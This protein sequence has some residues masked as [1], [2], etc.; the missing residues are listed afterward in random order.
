MAGLVVLPK[1]GWGRP[2][3]TAVPAAMCRRIRRKKGGVTHVLEKSVVGVAGVG[4][5]GVG[6]GGA[7]E[8]LHGLDDGDYVGG[9]GAAALDGVEAA[10]YGVPGSLG[11]V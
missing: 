1:L 4:V 6:D 5:S 11:R 7:E 10:G 3:R 8:L 2:G 9:V